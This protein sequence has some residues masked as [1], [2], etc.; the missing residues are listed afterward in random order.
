VTTVV[1]V[2]FGGYV[3]FALLGKAEEYKKAADN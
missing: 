2:M 3:M 1:L